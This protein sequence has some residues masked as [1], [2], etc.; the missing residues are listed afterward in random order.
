M[1]CT[2]LLAAADAA[3]EF[4]S[5]IKNHVDSSEIT[6][7]EGEIIDRSLLPNPSKS[8]YPNCRFTAHFR[9]NS[10]RKGKSIP[11][12]IIIIIEG[13]EKYAYLNTNKI[14]NGDKVKISI[15]PFETLKDDFKSTQIADDINA[16]DKE[17]FIPY[18]C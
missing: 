6:I 4:H 14:K 13:F 2:S 18:P 16:Y 8:D 5:E 11:K 7:V 17:C 10:I 12:E 3:I 1:T 9:E 15:V